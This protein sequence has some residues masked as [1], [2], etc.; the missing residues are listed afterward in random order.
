MPSIRLSYLFFPFVFLAAIPIIILTTTIFACA[1]VYVCAYVLLGYIFDSIFY[2]DSGFVGKFL[3][4]LLP[5][6]PIPTGPP[7][8]IPSQFQRL[9]VHHPWPSSN[10]GTITPRSGRHSRR[11]SASSETAT[12]ADGR[13]R[14]VPGFPYPP[15]SAQISPKAHKSVPMRHGTLVSA[16]R[17]DRGDWE[18]VN[19][20]H[21]DDDNNN[22]AGY[23]D[24]CSEFLASVGRHQG[25]K[26]EIS[27]EP[28]SNFF[29]GQYDGDVNGV[30]PTGPRLHFDIPPHPRRSSNGGKDPGSSEVTQY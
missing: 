13:K 27:A 14:S 8:P 25:P 28:K 23:E 4:A 29:V 5:N 20:E 30:L 3:T 6:Q 9:D 10:P 7:P 26:T 12:F 1:C 19:D 15:Q 16:Q 21:E 24:R 22:T 2:S 18:D 11:P 17:E